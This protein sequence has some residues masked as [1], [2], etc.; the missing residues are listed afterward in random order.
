VHP[1][2]PAEVLGDPTLA[3]R[4]AARVMVDTLGFVFRVSVRDCAEPF[5]RATEAALWRW[6]IPPVDGAASFA[7]EVRYGASVELGP[8]SVAEPLPPTDPPTVPIS[9]LTITKRKEPAVSATMVYLSQEKGIVEVFCRADLVVSA[10][11]KVSELSVHECHPDLVAPISKA[12]AKWRF[13][14]PDGLAGGRR[15][16]LV[17]PVRSFAETRGLLP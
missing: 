9:A 8:L 12:V 5:A 4:C 2:L 7:L 16:T 17:M 6:V 11:G 13:A 10:K 1:E 15:V 3:E 14:S